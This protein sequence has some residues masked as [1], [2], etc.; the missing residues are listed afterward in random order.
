MGE[1]AA[2]GQNTAAECVA[3]GP[4]A[5]YVVENP[6]ATT[7]EGLGTVVCSTGYYTLNSAQVLCD[8]T[9]TFVYSGCEPCSVW[10]HIMGLG[11]GS[12]TCPTGSFGTASTT[13]VDGVAVMDC[14]PC[15]VDTVT[16]TSVRPVGTPCPVDYHSVR[17]DNTNEN[18]C[19]CA[20]TVSDDDGVDR[21]FPID[22]GPCNAAT[23]AALT[24]LPECPT[25]DDGSF[26][27]LTCPISCSVV[28]TPFWSRCGADAELRMELGAEVVDAL[29]GFMAQCPVEGEAWERTMCVPDRH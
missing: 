4:P 15:P 24:N 10:A 21:C 14:R 1:R 23:L 18:S 20:A 22:T 17:T 8:G 29:E 2:Q 13:V 3:A 6:S 19:V 12:C 16:Q 28:A 25:A 7:V 26:V 5:A 9:G 11:G 27:P